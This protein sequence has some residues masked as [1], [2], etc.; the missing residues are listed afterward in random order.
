VI[1]FKREKHQDES[2]MIETSGVSGSVAGSSS[3][4]RVHHK[5]EHR[6]SLE[7]LGHGTRWKRLL[8]LLHASFSSS[9]NRIV[10]NSSR[11]RLTGVLLSI[12][13]FSFFCNLVEFLE[14]LTITIPQTMLEATQ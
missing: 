10:P 3:P 8:Q 12:Q 14:R 5:K 6:S 9:S 11:A 7:G 13:T 2:G 4:Q 1:D